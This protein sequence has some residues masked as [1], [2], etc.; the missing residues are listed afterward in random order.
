[1]IEIIESQEHSGLTLADYAADA[2]FA[3]LVANLRTEVELLRERLNGR[4]VWMINSTAQGG[5]VAEMLPRLIGLMRELGIATRWAVINTDRMEFFE[6]TKRIHNLIHGDARAGAD[7]T[8]TDA[9]L[10]EHVNRVNAD[11]FRPHLKTGDVLIVHDPQPLPLGQMLAKEAG[12]KAFW[13]CHIGLDQRTD[14]T[15]AAWRFLRPYLDCYGHAIFSLP[16][17]I[18]SFLAGHASI[19]YPALDPLSHKNR[20]LPVHKIVGILCNSGLQT[21]HEPVASPN[22][23]HQ[24]KRLTPDGGAEVPGEMGLL[25]RPTVVQVSRWD[26]LKGWLPLMDGFTRLKQRFTQGKL[27]KIDPRF[28]SQIE[29]C[30]L[31]LAGPD[32]ASIADDPEGVACFEE[33]RERY[34]ALSPDL[35]QD[36]AVLQLPMESRKENALIVNALQRCASIVAQNSIREGFGL[37]V[38]EAMWKHVT[39]LGSHACGIRLQVRDGLDGRLIRNSEDPDEI[40][41]QLKGMLLSPID[42]QLMGRSAQ[43]RVYDEFLIFRQISHYMEILGREA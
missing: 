7:F 23:E 36:V 20:E 13:R 25:F 15:R 9:Q 16:E 39:V 37:T 26:R 40:A 34:R 35:L 24:V 18:P 8:A 11:A 31:V 4:T 27:G 42:R 10:F 22:F 29:L 33:I 3:P 12:V 14:A 17:Y 5:G 41:E 38:A 28:A 32:P 30:R 43:R 19:I 2:K 6:L 1:M 21:Q